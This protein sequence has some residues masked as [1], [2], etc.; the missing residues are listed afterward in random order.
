MR[1][2]FDLDGRL[3]EFAS[4]IIDVSELPPKTFAGRHIASQ[5][6]RLGTS[7]PFTME[8]HKAQNPLKT[9]FIK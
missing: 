7:P 5:L 2:K 8:R 3:I 6:V 1:K 9:S 4:K